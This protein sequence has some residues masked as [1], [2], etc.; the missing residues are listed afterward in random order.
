MQLHDALRILRVRIN[1]G[2][3]A[4]FTL[5]DVVWCVFPFFPVTNRQTIMDKWKVTK[6][7][8]L[9]FLHVHLLI[10]SMY[11][12]SIYCTSIY[13]WV[14]GQ[15]WYTLY[16]EPM[17]TYISHRYPTVEGLAA[18]T[19]ECWQ[20]CGSATGDSTGRGMSPTSVRRACRWWTFYQKWLKTTTKIQR[21]Q[22]TK[23]KNISQH[24]IWVN[25]SVQHGDKTV[26]DKQVHRFTKS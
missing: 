2:A 16:M 15:C 9:D 17:G 1:T 3:A 8:D 19:R 4:R 21:R 11:A 13:I 7:S 12:W 22:N 26:L 5:I 25:Y 14:M 20:R 10:L 18:S 24:I 23:K 6:T